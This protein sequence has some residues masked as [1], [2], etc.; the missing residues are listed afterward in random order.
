[1]AAATLPFQEIAA[2]RWQTLAN[3]A[4]EPNGYYLRDWTLAADAS[5]RGCGGARALTAMSAGDKPELIALLPV[6]SLWRA[7]AIP[8]PALVSASTYGALGTPLIAGDA[9][10]AAAAGLLQQ[11]QRT[12]ARA[13]ILRD[14]PLD[15]AAMAALT[16]ALSVTAAQPRILNA[17]A[18]ACLDA[19]GDA[20]ALLRD[21]LGARK[22]KELRR[23]HNRLADHGEV[24]F[25]VARTPE[26]VAAAIEIFLQLEASGWKG[27]RGTAL[28]NHAGDAAF[29]RR[30][31]MAEA[32]QS[33]CE[34]AT[35]HAGAEAVAA[36]IVLRHQDRAFYFK[37]GVD[38]RFAKFSPGVQL[39][40]ALTRHLCADPAIAVADSTALPRHPMIDPIWR[41]RLRIGDVL[42]P[43][44][45]DRDPVVTAIA[46]AIAAR[47][48]LR[49]L[50][51][52][53]LQF[54]R[55]H[56]KRTP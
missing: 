50:A 11:A 37:L 21:G 4:A 35:L 1:M 9:A 40:L 18:R 47:R 44:H 24:A 33:R 8:L 53:S 54:I 28:A 17:H 29:I 52:D 48:T 12:G 39:T 26:Q 56:R 46:T 42:L 55:K 16:A 23:Q 5:A 19:T 49:G 25:R 31:T 14:L 22:L 6:V 43:L 13:L 32:A 10:A 7:L 34:I 3:R 20:E 15:G 41:G 51:R 2:D 36:G 27:R 38:E 30:A 45:G